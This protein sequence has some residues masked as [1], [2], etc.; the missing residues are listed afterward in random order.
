LSTAQQKCCFS[1]NLLLADEQVI[2][3]SEGNLQKGVFYL[4]KIAGEY[5][6]EISTAKT[7]VLA[8]Q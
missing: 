1:N 6:M 3:I 5:N 4:F 7:K 8:Y 2:I